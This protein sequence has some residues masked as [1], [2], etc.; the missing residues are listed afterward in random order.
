MS[1]AKAPLQLALEACLEVKVRDGEVL[2]RCTDATAKYLAHPPAPYPAPLICRCRSFRLP[3]EPA[4]HNKLRADYDWRTWEERGDV[5]VDLEPRRK[6]AVSS[7][8]DYG[9]E[10]FA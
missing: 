10:W 9:E 6:E 8:R 4:R 7:R 1:A 5:G 2:V 3:H